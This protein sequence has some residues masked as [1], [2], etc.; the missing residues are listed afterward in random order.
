[1]PEKTGNGGHGL[2]AYDPETG[3][4]IKEGD[5]KYH[6]G[7]HFSVKEISEM[8]TE[9]YY[10]DDFK[11][12]FVSGDDDAKTA[13]IGY[14]QTK[15]DNYYTKNKLENQKDFK[16]LSMAEFNKYAAE[17]KAKCDPSDYSFFNYN[18]R[19]AGSVSLEF[20]KVLRTGD[21]KY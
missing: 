6:A 10:G 14:L 2:E 21:E 7:A 12:L 11:Q 1:M 13:L 19:G 5:S 16:S 15:L 20:N 9:G 17:C 4:Y 18:Y 8:I 3:R